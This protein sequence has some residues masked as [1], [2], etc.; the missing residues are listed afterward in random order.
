MTKG[1][2]R[3]FVKWFFISVNLLI[4][5][6]FLFSC[7][8]PLLNPKDW[9]MIGFLPLAVPYLTVVLIFFLIFWL[10]VKPVRVLIPLITLMIGWKQLS[11]IFAWHPSKTFSNDN[12]SDSVLRIVSWN[13]RGMYGL[14]NSGYTQN[15][16]RN[17]IASLVNSLNADV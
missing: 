5:F 3:K 6:I 17:D 16:N 10:I 8:S 2:F 12:K 4:S 14:S 15:R 7:L 11:V 13:V 1:F 9:P